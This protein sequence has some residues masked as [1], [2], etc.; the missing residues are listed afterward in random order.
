MIVI[1]VSNCPNGDWCERVWL[2]LC[3]TAVAWQP[4]RALHRYY[5]S[6]LRSQVALASATSTPNSGNGNP[7]GPPRRAQLAQWC[8]DN[9][10]PAAAQPRKHPPSTVEIAVCTF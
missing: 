3:L 9:C 10:R 6:F 8:L 5:V 4:S 7:D 1:K 2:V